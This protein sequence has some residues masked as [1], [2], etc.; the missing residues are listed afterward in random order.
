MLKVNNMKT[1][2][3]G[4]SLI[5]VMLSLLILAV[6]I[7]GISKLQG[8][9]IKSSSDANQRSIATSI[10][11][12]KIDDLKSFAELTVG[13]VADTIPDVWVSGINPILL[14]F[15]HIA[16]NQGGAPSGTTNLTASTFSIGNYTYSLSWDVTD[17]YYTGTPTVATTPVPAGTDTDFKQVVVTVAWSDEDGTNQSV[18][19]DTVIDSYA[20][21]F[22]ALADNSNSGTSPPNVSFN[23]GVAPE[24]VYTDQGDLDGQTGLRREATTPDITVSSNNQFVEYDVKFVTYNSS[25]VQLKAEEFRFVNCVCTQE[26]AD[27]TVSYLPSTLT[28]ILDDETFDNEFDPDS[29]DFK[30]TGKKRG[31]RISTGQNGQ[32]SEDCNICCRDHH[33]MTAHNSLDEL[34]DPFRPSSDYDGTTGDHNHYYPDNN[35]DLQLANDVGDTYL[36][37][38]ALVKVDGVYRVTQ[39]FNLLTVKTMPESFLLSPSGFTNYKNYKEAYLLEYAKQLDS[40]TSFPAT[41]IGPVGDSITPSIKYTLNDPASASDVLLTNEPDLDSPALAVGATNNLRAKTLYTRHIPSEVMTELKAVVDGSSTFSDVSNILP[42]YDPDGTE[43]AQTNEDT[44]AW[45]SAEPTQVTVDQTGLLTALA[46]T[47]SAGILVTATRADSNTSFTNTRPIDPND[48]STSYL[49]SDAMTV[50]VSGTATTTQVDVRVTITSSGAS[51]INP[52]SVTV[53]GSNG[54]TCGLEANNVKYVYICSF[55]SG[56][57]KLTISDYNDSYRVMGNT[58]VVDNQAC[59]SGETFTVSDDGTLDEEAVINYSGLVDPVT[60]K[61]INIVLESDGC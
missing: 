2:N 41:K 48:A 49:T 52:N 47:D 13:T 7:L 58:V 24:I 14:S 40:E 27:S 32:Q 3:F 29:T 19:L 25:N 55:T 39:D 18:S 46:A 23:P 5:E 16:D 51:G 43:I 33:D 22:S 61:T 42:F 15:E 6:G 17:F 60:D 26:A 37:A 54:A 50:V 21:A 57:G 38:C 59:L 10:A 28:L 44:S 11:Q 45:G 9:L 4:F 34:F 56:T 35:G 53:A 1:K 20:P 30:V 36:E 12:R 31:S 8:T